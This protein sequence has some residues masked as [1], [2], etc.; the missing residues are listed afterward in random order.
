MA[1]PL[2]ARNGCEGINARRQRA[3]RGNADSCR[4]AENESV[5]GP[6]THKPGVGCLCKPSDGGE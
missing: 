3:E 5:H 1:L 6:R 4:P 2:Q